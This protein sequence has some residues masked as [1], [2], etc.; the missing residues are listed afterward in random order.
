MDKDFNH[1]VAVWEDT[2]GTGRIEGQ[3]SC[4]AI[5]RYIESGPEQVTGEY[6]PLALQ[7]H[8]KAV[9]LLWQAIQDRRRA[10]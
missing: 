6:C 4:G 8:P 3:C 5:W 7:R 10:V 2:S 9:E 1:Y